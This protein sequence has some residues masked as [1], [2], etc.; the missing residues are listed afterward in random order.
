M[1]INPIQNHYSQTNNQ[2][3]ID[4]FKDYPAAAQAAIELFNT[5]TNKTLG[6]NQITFENVGNN[7]FYVNYFDSETNS[8]YHTEIKIINNNTFL[9][10]CN[11][12]PWTY[13]H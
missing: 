1:S 3:T 4:L 9:I 7:K 10:T 8:D 5:L 2:T 6:N 13:S 12:S 11:G